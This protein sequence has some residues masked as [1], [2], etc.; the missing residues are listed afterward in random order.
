MADQPDNIKVDIQDNFQQQQIQ[1]SG[2]T[3]LAFKVE[4]SKVPEFLGQKAKDTIWALNF[5][6][7]IDDLARM[8]CTDTHR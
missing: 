5:M 6:R 7:R 1:A 2:H 3:T 8:N 4:H